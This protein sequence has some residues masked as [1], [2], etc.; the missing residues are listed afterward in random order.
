MRSWTDVNMLS[1]AILVLAAGVLANLST[2]TV[3]VAW[4]CH[5]TTVLLHQMASAL[6][7]LL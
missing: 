6:S 4:L 1:V 2:L 3:L 7:A 5:S